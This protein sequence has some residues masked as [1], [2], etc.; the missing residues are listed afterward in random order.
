MRPLLLFL[1]LLSQSCREVAL[2]P[3]IDPA[4]VSIEFAAQV[5][6]PNDPDHTQV[7]GRQGDITVQGSVR[8]GQHGY[9]LVPELSATG[10]LRLVVFAELHMGI[11]LAAHYR[12]EARLGRLPAG[13]YPL[14][15]VHRVPAEHRGWI[16]FDDMVTVR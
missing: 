6:G 11:T 3:P 12:Y 1:T 16:V 5:V 8:T 10:G 13:R 15:V 9:E 2:A 4:D 7:E 14:T